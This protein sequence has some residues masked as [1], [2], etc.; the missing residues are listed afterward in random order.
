M[1]KPSGIFGMS[2][3]LK[4]SG[5]FGR[6]SML[7][8]SGIFGMSSMLKPSGIFGMS[9]MLKPSGIFGM[10]SMSK[11]SGIFGIKS[12]TSNGEGGCDPGGSHAH[13]SRSNLHTS[14]IGTGGEFGSTYSSNLIRL[15]GENSFIASSGQSMSSAMSTSSTAT[16]AFTSRW[17]PMEML[18]N[19]NWVEV[20]CS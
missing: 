5:I 13:D 14:V 3:M 11:P 8:P 4:P 1:L 7:K 6:S 2:V 12:S 17:W 20:T 10:P 19:Q 9:S 18:T 15:N 16:V